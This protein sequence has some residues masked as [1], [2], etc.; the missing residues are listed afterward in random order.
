MT[1][2]RTLAA[3]DGALVVVAVDGA[4]WAEGLPPVPGGRDVTVAFSSADASAEH[5]EAV[6]L[7]GYRV[8]G[9]RD[10]GAG[11]PAAE[12]LVPRAVVEE[13]PAW[14][15]GLTDHAAQVFSLA[16][17]PVRRS[18]APALAVHIDD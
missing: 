4:R 3:L 12:F 6:V 9:V 18:I 5:A 13:H 8:V 10:G 16:F 14:W 15:R 7:L 1:S 17:G 11:P 2:P